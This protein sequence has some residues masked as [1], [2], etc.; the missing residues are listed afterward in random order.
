MLNPCIALPGYLLDLVTISIASFPR[1][2]KHL[3]L[4]RS[5]KGLSKCLIP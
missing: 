4:S 2:F 5:P 3:T 1:A